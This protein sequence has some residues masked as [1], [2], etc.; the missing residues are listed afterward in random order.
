MVPFLR[1]SARMLVLKKRRLRVA[2]IIEPHRAGDEVDSGLAVDRPAHALGDDEVAGGRVSPPVERNAE[3]RNQ[4]RV[5][6][7]DIVRVLVAALI[8]AVQQILLRR[9]RENGD[10]SAHG[11][12]AEDAGGGAARHLDTLQFFRL[13]LRP[14]NPSSERIVGGNAVP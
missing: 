11:P 9:P 12:V 13:K 6:G 7:R 5:T 4:S 3:L 10:R 2:E 14:V 1:S 8:L